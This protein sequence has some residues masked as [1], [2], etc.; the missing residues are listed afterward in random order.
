MEGKVHTL[1]SGGRLHYWEKGA[2]NAV[3]LVHGI[4]ANH[5]LWEGV[6]EALPD[7]VRAIAPDWPLGSQPE[8]FPSSADLS[9]EGLVAMIGEFMEAL[10][11]QD[12]TLVG[13]DSG[14]G[15]CQLLITSDGPFAKR[16]GR[17]VLTNSDVLDQFPPKGFRPMQTMARWVP[18]IASPLFKRLMRRDDYK[19]FFDMTCSKPVPSEIKH[20]IL[21]P[22]VA[23]AKAR[24]GSLSFLVGCKPEM[25]LEATRKFSA[26]AAPVLL[27]WG[28]DDSLFPLELAEK[29]TREFRDVRL[30]KVPGANLF[31][32][33]DEPDRVA[34]E[35]AT[36][37]GAPG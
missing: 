14:G 24:R 2:G 29:L 30:V 23:N 17:L 28:E 22:F 9:P 21:G 10:D 35:V 16:V 4:W 5:V 3:L 7:T 8:S 32:P 26:F 34:R 36:F 20:R 19:M 18:W 13:N 25:M 15:L 37:A 11:L 33:L 12:V 27:I 6:I 1:T 31:V